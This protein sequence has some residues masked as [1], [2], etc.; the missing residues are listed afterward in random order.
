MTIMTNGSFWLSFSSLILVCCVSTLKVIYTFKCVDFNC[1]GLS[2][3][4][5]IQVEANLDANLERIPLSRKN[6]VI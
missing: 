1:C 3:H 2:I 5:D 4:R 6:S